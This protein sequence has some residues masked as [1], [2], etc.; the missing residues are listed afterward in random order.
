MQTNLRS[1]SKTSETKIL[2][3]ASGLN[4]LVNLLVKLL[5]RSNELKSMHCDP[6]LLALVNSLVHN[7]NQKLQLDTDPVLALAELFD[8]RL[9]GDPAQTRHFTALQCITKQIHEHGWQLLINAY[10]PMNMI[11]LFI[12]L[13]RIVSFLMIYSLYYYCLVLHQHDIYYHFLIKSL[14]FYNYHCHQQLQS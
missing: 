4:I 11:L 10:N 1:H 12:I 14:L 5:H 2:P 13:Y 7:L 8:P 3:I 6:S 9:K